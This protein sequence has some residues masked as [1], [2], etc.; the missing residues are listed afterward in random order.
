MFNKSS[1]SR[2]IAICLAAML[3][4][5]PAHAQMDGGQSLSEE[6]ALA[7]HR[8]VTIG[9][10]LYYRDAAAWVA[11]DAL[12]ER[13][14]AEKL[15]S[16]GVMGWVTVPMYDRGN[17]TFPI[18]YQV[19]FL[20]EVDGEYRK[21]YVAGVQGWGVLSD[22]VFLDPSSRPGLKLIEIQAF[23]AKKAAS[24]SVAAD[25]QCSGPF[26]TV[27]IPTET[28]HDVYFLSPENETGQVQIGG[29]Y[30]ISVAKDLSLG[31][32]KPIT[33]SC[34]S[35]SLGESEKDRPEALMVTHALG[36][37]PTEIHVFKSMSHEIPL[38]VITQTNGQVW[39]VIG[40]YISMIE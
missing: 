8:A 7:V 23:R 29:H 35:L 19:S 34:L 24:A 36:P 2:W 26:N 11:T 40:S 33:N 28:G 16:L 25:R 3:F 15:G 21:L 27:V 9:Q 1:V 18:V 20:T 12:F 32:L 4:W 38:F 5:T 6:D 39:K 22:S 10:E 30:K 13:V 37:V 17:D 31:E 14:S